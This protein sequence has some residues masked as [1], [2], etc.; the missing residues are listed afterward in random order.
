MMISKEEYIQGETEDAWDDYKF[1]NQ[2]LHEYFKDQVKHL[3]DKEFKK[4]LED[5]GWEVNGG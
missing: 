3:T 5:L 1:V 2:I 4:Y